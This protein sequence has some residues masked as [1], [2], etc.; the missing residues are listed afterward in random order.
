MEPSSI[1]L[2]DATNAVTGWYDRVKEQFTDFKPEARSMAINFSRGVSQ[3][4]FQITVPDGWRKKR[5]KV[6]IP[7]ISGYKIL[8]M[9]D[10][11]FREQKQLW[12]LT[13][14][15]FVLNANELPASE[16]YLVVMEGNIDEITLKNL[17]YIKPA[18]NRDNDN[19]NDKYWLDASIRQPKIFEKIYSDLEVD[20]VNVR[21]VINIDKM[22]GLTLPSEVK[23]K[24]LAVQELLKASSNFDRNRLFKAALEYKRQEKISPSFDPG[25]FF[26]IIQRLTAG[27]IIRQHI[28]VD[29]PYDIG[30]I[31]QPEKYINI[32]PQNIKVQTITRL[33]LQTPIATGYLVFKREKYLEK[34]RSEFKKIV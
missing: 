17:V 21:V 6:M 12:K 5:R 34:L 29:R 4:G 3:I 27:D 25:N 9:T 33:S 11:G 7:A 13:D 28:D 20:D 23:E 2:A 30:D 22:F 19:E 8:H 1:S 31:E 14:N 32:V 26:K 10:E 18:A 15:H 16:H 24:A